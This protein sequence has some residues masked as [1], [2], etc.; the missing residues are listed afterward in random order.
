MIIWLNGT[1]GVGKSTVAK[2]IKSKI[3]NQDLVIMDPDEFLESISKDII[4]DLILHGGGC[5]PQNNKMFLERFKE[6]LKMYMDSNTICIVP[7]ALTTKESIEILWDHI[8]QNSS[9]IFQFILEAEEK[10]II[11]RVKADTERQQKDFAEFELSSNVKFLKK[12][13]DDIERLDTNDKTVENIADLIISKI[14]IIL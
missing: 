4:E 7:M 5:M 3:S 11:N 2:E 8:S 13:F 10:T 14:G 6:A 12:N 1:Y 9:D